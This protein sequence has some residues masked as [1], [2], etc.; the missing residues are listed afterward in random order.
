VAVSQNPP[1]LLLEAA[2]PG[3]AQMRTAESRQ[4]LAQVSAA[5]TQAVLVVSGAAVCVILAV[6]HGFVTWW[7]GAERYG[8]L[9]L[10]AGLAG[11][12][13][14][15]HWSTTATYALFALGHERRI[16]VTILADGAVTVTGQILLTRAFG[17]AGTA[18]GTLAGVCLVSLPANL[19]GLTAATGGWRTHLGALGP[20]A[21]R[22]SLAAALSLAVA[23]S[24]RPAR[25]PGLVAVTLAVGGA[26]AAMAFPLAWRGALATYVRP[27]VARLRGPAA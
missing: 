5:L 14:L 22:F 12:M 6:N 4:R 24:W 18:L 2:Q 20:W 13:L 26:Y 27:L 11:A 8:G 10:T 1:L 9:G 19:T 21:W 3:L 25:V 17:P 15:R 16:A 23:I 7:V